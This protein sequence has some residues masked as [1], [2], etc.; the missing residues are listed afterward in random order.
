MKF[1]DRWRPSDDRLFKTASDLYAAV[2]DP[3]FTGAAALIALDHTCVTDD[4]ARDKAATILAD[5]SE[6]LG[7]GP[8]IA[9]LALHTL[10]PE[11]QTNTPPPPEQYRFSV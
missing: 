7:I 6:R 2:T 10:Y 11:L 1:G 8:D 3:E 4:G 5:A 9:Q